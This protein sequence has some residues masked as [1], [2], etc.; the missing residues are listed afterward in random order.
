MVFRRIIN[1]FRSKKKEEKEGNKEG[2][3]DIEREKTEGEIKKRP[4]E[5][6]NKYEEEGIEEVGIITKEKEIKVEGEEEKEIIIEEGEEK[7]EEE[8]YTK[9]YKEEE[10]IKRVIAIANQKG[11]VGKSTT[12]VN[13]SASMANMEK[14]VI[15]IDIDPQANATSGLGISKYE[16]NS[17]IYDAIIE[18]VDINELIKET[19]IDGLFII[20]SN[21][22]LAGAE[23]EMT[24]M[25]MR[26]QKLRRIIEPIREKYDFIIIDCPPALGILTINALVAADEILIPIQCE[27]YALEGLGQLLRTIELVKNNLNKNLKICG[28][29]MTMYDSRLKLSNEVVEEVRKHFGDK[30]YK[31]IIPRN[32]RVSEAPSYGLPVN[33]YDP[34]CKGAIAYENF[35]KEV[36]NYGKKRFGERT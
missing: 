17:S 22:H 14:K 4:A 18:K 28:F 11:G 34:D 20:P 10:E 1:F 21:I 23:V 12:A 27:Y 16:V 36:I 3:A 29:V 33:L 7:K 31:T 25:M 30:V 15:L 9:I 13:M 8:D 6:V 32:V 35:T 2:I 24:N 5:E 26:E 19:K